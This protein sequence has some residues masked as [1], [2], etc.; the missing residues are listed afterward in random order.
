MCAVVGASIAVLAGAALP[1]AAGAATSAAKANSAPVTLSATPLGLDVGPWDTLYSDPTKLSMMQSYLK[2]AGIGQLHYG[3][4]GTADQYDWENNTVVN[5]PTE[6]T[7]A[8]T[9]A[10]FSNPKCARVEPLDFTQFSRM[11][12]RSVRRVT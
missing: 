5:N 3:G 2:A 10:S 6:C 12:G 11:R 1:G 8:P 4:G 9:P 7:N